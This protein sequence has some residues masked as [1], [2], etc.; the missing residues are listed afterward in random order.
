MQQ[1][2]IESVNGHGSKLSPQDLIDAISQLQIHEPAVIGLNI[3]TD[4]IDSSDDSFK[5]LSDFV[6]RHSNI[7][8]AEG[9]LPPFIDPLLGVDPNKVGF[10]DVFIDQD[11][12]V[13]RMPLG[14]FDLQDE[15][16]FKYSFSFL[17]AKVYLEE[18]GHSLE[19]GIL[20]EEAMRFGDIEISKIYPNTGGYSRIDDVG[21]QTMV[22]YRTSQLPFKVI[23]FQTLKERKL[24]PSDIENR[25]VIIGVTDVKKRFRIKPPV[26]SQMDGLHLTGHFTSQIINSVLEDRFLIKPSKEVFEYFLIIL[27]GITIIYF[28][29]QQLSTFQLIAIETFLDKTERIDK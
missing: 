2:P 8:S 4:L 5:E 11:Y 17:L 14:S 3:P 13:R 15:T 26:A 7:I 18:Y 12:Y 6:S 23:N 21:I 19:N 10:V 29:N 25:L 22:N 28:C 9:F 1:S 24:K 27:S 20:D 16:Q